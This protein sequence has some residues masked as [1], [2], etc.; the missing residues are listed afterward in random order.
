MSSF[1]EKEAYKEDI[2]QILSCDF[3]WDRLDGKNILVTG[4]TGMI[5][6][7]LTDALML[8]PA[9]KYDVFICGRN[10][11]A[12]RER[13]KTYWNDKSFHFFRQDL[14]KGFE[15]PVPVHYVI[16]GA[17]Y[18]FPAAFAKDPFG[19]LTG[20]VT[21]TANLLENLAKSSALERMLY[22]SSGEVYGK[23]QDMPW[24][25]HDSGYVDPLDPRS[26]Y[27][28]AKRAAENL[29]SAAAAQ[30]GMSISI[31]RLSHVY[32]AT[33]TDSDNRAYVQFIRKAVAGEDIVLKSDGSQTR[34]YCYVADCASA[35]LHI[36]FYGEKDMAYNVADNDSF[37]SVRQMAQTI[38]DCAGVS[39]RFEIPDSAE[40][41]GYSTVK[42]IGLDDS[43]IRSLGWK[44]ENSLEKGIGKILSIKR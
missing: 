25:E 29:C 34:S 40:S 16:H 35:L 13:F 44:P 6:S 22:I 23:A 41:K 12:A 2:R 10:E 28:T 11:D 26:C 8:N 32:G 14:S 36:L 30:F 17:G 4:A 18:S 38:A 9:R 1:L 3:P 15:C 33:F 39:L 42:A 31:A 21:G 43:R 27:P 37:V 24:T 5:C 19:T 7:V 20:N